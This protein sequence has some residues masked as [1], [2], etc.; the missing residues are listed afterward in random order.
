MGRLGVIT[1]NIEITALST[2]NDLKANGNAKATNGFI[3]GDKVINNV[4]ILAHELLAT[5]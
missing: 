4:R 2:N 3:L 1:E 5:A